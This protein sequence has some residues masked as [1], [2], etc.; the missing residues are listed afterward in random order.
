MCFCI[1]FSDVVL[2]YTFDLYVERP[3]LNICDRVGHV[4]GH[5]SL[6]ILFLTLDETEQSLFQEFP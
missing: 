4:T 1:R 3:F 6:S 2:C 5:Q